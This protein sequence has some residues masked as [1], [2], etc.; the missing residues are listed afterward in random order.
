MSK[1]YRCKTP[2]NFKLS[3]RKNKLNQYTCNNCM[4]LE[5]EI[6]KKLGIEYE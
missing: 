5:N 3:Y 6:N 2:I 4:L 1:C